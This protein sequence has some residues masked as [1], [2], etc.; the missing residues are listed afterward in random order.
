MTGNHLMILNCFNGWH[1]TK[2]VLV[3]VICIDAMILP[4]SAG[5]TKR[6]QS[7]QKVW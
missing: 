7:E 6:I 4:C 2:G 1:E 5:G 3:K